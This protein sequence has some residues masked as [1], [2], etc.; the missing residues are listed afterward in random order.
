MNFR[1]IPAS[2]VKQ[3][4]QPVKAKDIEEA[5]T[6]WEWLNDIPGAAIILAMAI[7]FF[8]WLGIYD[9]RRK[10]RRKRRKAQSLKPTPSTQLPLEEP[11]LTPT[12]APLEEAKKA[13][14][15]EKSSKFY[16]EV[17]KAVWKTLSEKLSIPPAEM[18]KI[19]AA[20]ILSV[21]GA[22][23]D[24]INTLQAVLHECEMALYTPGHTTAD[25]QHT[26]EK[27]EKVINYLQSS[28]T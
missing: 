15:E 22:D 4:V 13:I 12:T 7:L 1:V 26:L 19:N 21:R 6:S 9:Y 24:T 10:R 3:A 11:V 25:M 23:N 20:S 16:A 17:N 8:A 27:A 2:T 28:L 18:N 14:K 5:E